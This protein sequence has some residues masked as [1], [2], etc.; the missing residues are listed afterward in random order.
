VEAALRALGVRHLVLAIHD[1]S[2]PG[3]SDDDIGYGAPAS[4]AGRQLAGFARAS[5]FDA[6]Q[7]GPQGLTGEDDASPYTGTLFSRNPLSISLARLADPHAEWGELLP[8]SRLAALVASRPPGALRRVPYRSVFRDQRMA[9]GAAFERFERRR[10]SGD[11]G[12]RRL[13]ER[14]DDFRSEAR[15]WLEA[16]ALYEVLRGQYAGRDWTRWTG[17]HAE[18][19]RGLGDFARGGARAAARRTELSQRYA[20]AI[21]FYCFVQLVAHEQHAAFREDARRLGLSIFGDLQVGISPRDT[22]RHPG[23]FLERYRMG[24]PPSRTNPDGQPWD[25]PVLDP[26]AYL[27]EGRPGP[28]LRF[29]ASRARKMFDE[30]DAIRIDHPQGLV[31]PWVYR[32][33]DPEARSEVRHGARLFS[34][35]D[36]PD[37]RELARYAIVRPSQLSPDPATP[38]Y[39]DRWVVDLEPEQ[40]ERYARVFDLVV[41]IA[42]QRGRA[43]PALFCEVL[44]TLPNPLA[45]VLARHDLGRFRVTQKADPGD[46]DDVYHAANAAPHDWIMFGNHDTPPLWRLLG[47]WQADGRIA[48]RAAHAARRLAP[49]AGERE[50]LRSRLLAEPGLLAHAEIAQ[51]FASPAE[52]V[53]IFFADL[54]GLTEVYNRPGTVS[55]ENWTLRLPPDYRN[56]YA[57]RLRADRALNLP[58]ALWMALRAQPETAP[59]ELV[60]ALRLEA[61][62]A[63]AGAP[64]P[65]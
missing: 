49:S 43:E 14:F 60:S 61:E 15:P 40:V 44:S 55:A 22:W 18:L 12:G 52:N 64:L 5:G 35:P 7:L 42:R 36:L 26:D 53:S 8:G 47:E 3:G 58:L 1:A 6:L 25:Y 46:P 56:G 20:E 11:A 24:A 59:P 48:A 37:H 41:Q 16:D 57:Q 45:R 2:F 63:R 23:M 17:P 21:R 38:R 65:G 51:L 39:D 29:V 27:S 32:V 54:F 50:A 19:D 13:G 31:C 30:F 33:D 10:A 34:S 28:A 9:L 62:T 4:P